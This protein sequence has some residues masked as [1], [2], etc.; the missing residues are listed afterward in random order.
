MQL[1]HQV[2]VQGTVVLDEASDLEHHLTYQ[3]VQ[4]NH[5]GLVNILYHQKLEAVSTPIYVALKQP[6]FNPRIKLASRV[7]SLLPRSTAWTYTGVNHYIVTE[8]QSISSP[9]VNIV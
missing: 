6:H 8:T 3:V 1:T 9:I 2:V 7:I 5:E 4:Y